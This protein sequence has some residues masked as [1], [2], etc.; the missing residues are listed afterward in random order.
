MRLGDARMVDVPILLEVFLNMSL[1]S[2]CSIGKAFVWSKAKLAFFG[3]L[4]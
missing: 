2:D 1:R 3:L 4:F